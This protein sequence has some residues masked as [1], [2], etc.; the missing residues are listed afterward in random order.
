MAVLRRTYVSALMASGAV[1]LGSNKYDLSP[2]TCLKKQ[3][4]VCRE[5]GAGVLPAN[6]G[7]NSSKVKTSVTLTSRVR[8]ERC[9]NGSW[10]RSRVQ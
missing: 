6:T 10:T 9:L 3:S 7:G 4:E 8:G 2:H 5:E 1:A